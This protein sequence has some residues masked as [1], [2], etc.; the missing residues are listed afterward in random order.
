MSELIRGSAST[1]RWSAYRVTSHGVL[2]STSRTLAS[3]PSCCFALSSGGGSNGHPFALA[4]GNSGSSAVVN[5]L[6]T[7]SFLGRINHL[8][9]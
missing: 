8:V 1:A 6:V 9:G 2:P 7:M 5:V 4:I 3:G